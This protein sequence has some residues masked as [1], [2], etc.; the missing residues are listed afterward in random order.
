[1]AMV[2]VINV[3]A[4]EEEEIMEMINNVLEIQHITTIQTNECKLI[5][6]MK[7]ICNKKKLAAVFVCMFERVNSSHLV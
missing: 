5:R 4:E 1:M 2:L 6:K 3:G 7:S